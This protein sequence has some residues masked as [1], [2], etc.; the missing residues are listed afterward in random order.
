MEKRVSATE[1]RIRFGEIMRAARLG[2]V[3]VERDGKPEVV[4]LSKAAY[5]DLILD[6]VSASELVKIAHQNVR[7]DLA[8]RKVK[9]LP[10]PEE[11]LTELREERY[12]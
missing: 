3:I 12:G 6:K 10:A 8:R 4:V 2:P 7:R 1:A 9:A 5:D 11:I